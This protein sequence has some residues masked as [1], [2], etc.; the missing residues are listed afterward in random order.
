M[1]VDVDDIIDDADGDVDDADG[2]GEVRRRLLQEPGRPARLR[3]NSLFGLVSAVCCNRLV[4]RSNG[5]DAAMM[6]LVFE[7]N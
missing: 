3:F 2:E 1:H 6:M 4:V 5:G 7:L